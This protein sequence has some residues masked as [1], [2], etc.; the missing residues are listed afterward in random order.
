MSIARTGCY[1][2][3]SQVMIPGVS[4]AEEN[5]PASQ[6]EEISDP[7]EVLKQEIKSLERDLT[8]LG[9]LTINQLPIDDYHGTVE[10]LKEELVRLQ[11]QLQ[12][13]QDNSK[14]PVK[15]IGLRDIAIRNIRKAIHRVS[16]NVSQSLDNNNQFSEIKPRERIYNCY[17]KRL[18]EEG[19]VLPDFD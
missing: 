9:Q 4:D 17:E 3:Q 12:Q 6:A 18:L 14:E 15:S 13:W 7:G 5:K 8:T 2:S 19:M 1:S 11:T 16:G 10:H